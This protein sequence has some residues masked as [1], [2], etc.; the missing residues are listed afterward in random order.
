MT[1]YRA[2]ALTA[3]LLVTL[4][5]ALILASGGGF[6]LL[7]IGAIILVSVLIERSY[8]TATHRPAGTNWQPTDE[9][10]VDP[11]SGKLVTV[12]FDPATGERRYVTD[13]EPHNRS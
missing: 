7:V 6:M 9:R 4:C 5:G 3:G 13:G 1:G 2:W 10:F 11:D 8:G 12:W